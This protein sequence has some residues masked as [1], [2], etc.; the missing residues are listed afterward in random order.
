MISST[1]VSPRASSIWASMP[2]RPTGS[3]DACSTWVSS[4]SS[5]TTWSGELALGSMTQSRFA[6]APSTTSI[7]SR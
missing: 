4:R 3:P 7:T 1:R 2:M 6:P 5:Q